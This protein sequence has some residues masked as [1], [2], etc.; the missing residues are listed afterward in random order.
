MNE[1]CVDRQ[2]QGRGIG[3]RFMKAIEAYLAENG[4][5]KNTKVLAID[6][7]PQ[8]NMTSGLGAKGKFEKSIYDVII[9]DVDAR[10]SIVPTVVKNLDLIASDISLSGAEVELVNTMAREYVL[11]NALTEVRKTYDYIVILSEKIDHT[12]FSFVTPVD[13]DNCAISHYKIIQK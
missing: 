9:N 1:F 4:K 8:G 13:S 6:L 11:R 7:D 3:S 5:E 10:D 2:Q 12:A